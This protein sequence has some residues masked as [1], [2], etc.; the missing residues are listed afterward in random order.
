MQRCSLI[1]WRAAVASRGGGRPSRRGHPMAN[2]PRNE[3]ENRADAADD[4]P[5]VVISSDS[6]AGLPTELYRDY[7][8]KEFHP[9]FDEFLAG[10]PAAVAEIRRMGTSD[11]KFAQKWFTENA[12]GL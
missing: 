12:E 7:L 5:Y 4:R 9:A 3:P 10:R 2:E 6:H 11:A 1:G 8:E